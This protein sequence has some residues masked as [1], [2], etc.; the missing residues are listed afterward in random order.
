MK[1]IHAT[2]LK[3]KVL[4]PSQHG[5]QPGHGTETANVQVLNVFEEAKANKRNLYGSSWDMAKAFDTITP[6]IIRMAW[7]RLGVPLEIV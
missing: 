2:L 3:H 4:H 5:F 6:D 7:V 1:T